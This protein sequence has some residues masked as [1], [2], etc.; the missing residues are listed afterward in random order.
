MVGNFTP[1]P[2][3]NVAAGVPSGGF[4][5]ERLNSDAT[6]YG[7]SGI[8][9]LGGVESRPVPSYGMPC[10]LTLTVPPLGCLFLSPP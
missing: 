9:N 10:S 7:G 4:W 2:R 5:R 8:G 6:V 1:V 3:D